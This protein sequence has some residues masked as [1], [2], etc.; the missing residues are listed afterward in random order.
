MKYALSLILIL[1]SSQAFASISDKIAKE[2][3]SSREGDLSTKVLEWYQGTLD[4]DPG[5]CG[6]D[7]N[8]EAADPDY[9]IIRLVSSSGSDKPLP[10]VSFTSTY[11]VTKS[12]FG[13]ATG[14]GSDRSIVDAV[15]IQGSRT[16]NEQADGTLTLTKPVRFK[17]LRDADKSQFEPV[18]N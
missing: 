18:Y 12:C 13:G 5:S 4:S 6:P 9:R 2:L 7:F 3:D 14:A 15:I 11:M 17:K 16:G 1:V 8:Q 10:T